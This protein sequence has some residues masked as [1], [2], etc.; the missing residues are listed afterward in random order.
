M[1]RRIT[2]RRSTDAHDRTKELLMSR[3][4]RISGRHRVGINATG[5]DA[6][7]IPRPERAH[8]LRKSRAPMPKM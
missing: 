8:R 7:R 2:T 4:A 1:T 3:A 6:N 5:V